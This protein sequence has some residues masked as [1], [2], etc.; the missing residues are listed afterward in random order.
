MSD[1]GITFKD[2]RGKVIDPKFGVTGVTLDYI[3]HLEST[4]AEQKRTIAAK[5]SE[6]NHLA[7][8][9]VENSNKFDRAV[10]DKQYTKEDVKWLEA[11]RICFTIKTVVTEDGRNVSCYASSSIFD[12]TEHV[13]VTT[14][15][16][17]S[18]TE[19][20]EYYK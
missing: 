20:P 11:V 5:E 10:A 13:W 3:L 14:C 6:C 4:I 15:K 16:P 12:D 7:N 2:S 18:K 17:L 9:I 8:L 19:A 1:F